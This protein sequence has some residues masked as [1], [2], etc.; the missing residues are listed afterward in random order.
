MALLNVHASSICTIAIFVKKYPDYYL[1]AQMSVLF[2][3]ADLA[4]NPPWASQTEKITKEITLR[5]M[6]LI[7]WT[8]V[9]T[10]T[11]HGVAGT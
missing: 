6:N 8:Q 5:M 7:Q 3:R 9:R 4:Q 11:L 1:S 2:L 10:Q